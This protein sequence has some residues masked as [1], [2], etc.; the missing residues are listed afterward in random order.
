MNYKI[1]PRPAKR[2]DEYDFVKGLLIIFVIWGH[3]CMYTTPNNYDGNSLTH[4]IR[5]FQMPLFI[6]ISGMFYKPIFDLKTGI[7]KSIKIFKHIAFPLIFWVIFT[8]I[9][10][11]V[12]KPIP[13]SIR[14]ILFELRGSL[15]I[16]WY[17]V[18]LLFCMYFTM[19]L[20]IVFKTRKYLWGGVISL[21]FIPINI[22][23]FQFLYLFFV[24]GISIAE[25]KLVIIDKWKKINWIKK[26]LLLLTIV[27]VSQYY[28]TSLT[29]YSAP[30][31]I[32]GKITL[33]IIHQ[34]YMVPSVVFITVRY[35]IYIISTIIWLLL[36][37]ELF[38]KLRKISRP[39]VFLGKETLFLFVSHLYILVSF[40]KILY[41]IFNCDCIILQN[42]FIRFYILDVM[43]SAI[44][45]IVLYRIGIYFN[46][47][48]TLSLW[49]QG[50]V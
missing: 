42:D 29:F 9:T 3:V 26:L 38:Q 6:M 39:I 13:L 28:P 37:C 19:M 16:Y 12:I 14:D 11:F 33:S 47:F 45:V 50:K 8:S 46:R 1:V 10:Q 2:V 17:F 36:F 41:D 25:Y 44:L 27:V 32:L 34:Q 23:N 7:E 4:I 24:L 21:L 35:L 49:I 15:S 30:N 22:Y 31:Y 40:S 43:I 5:L 20:T 18:C 48:K